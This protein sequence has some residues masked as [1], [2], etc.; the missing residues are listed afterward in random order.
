MAAR[1]TVTP[2]AKVPASWRHSVRLITELIETFGSDKVIDI[3]EVHGDVV[4]YFTEVGPRAVV[5]T[6]V[7]EIAVAEEDAKR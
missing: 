5:V 3:P 6:A 2:M 7:E 1:T 4:A